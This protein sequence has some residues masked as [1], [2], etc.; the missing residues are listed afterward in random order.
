M[1][2]ICVY[3]YSNHGYAFLLLKDFKNYLL[4][5]DLHIRKKPFLPLL[6]ENFW[7]GNN[8]C[9]KHSFLTRTG[10]TIDFTTVW[11]ITQK[12]NMEYILTIGCQASNGLPPY[13]SNYSLAHRFLISVTSKH[14]FFFSREFESIWR[15]KKEGKLFRYSL[16][17]G[18][19]CW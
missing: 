16:C 18:R 2:S 17:I 4:S 5:V 7:F 10:I 19:T 8:R 12:K 13:A 1:W 11:A 9:E 3:S 6:R 14:G 15:E